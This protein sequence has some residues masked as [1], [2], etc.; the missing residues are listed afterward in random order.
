MSHLWKHWSH[1]QLYPKYELD[2]IIQSKTTDLIFCAFLGS[3]LCYKVWGALEKGAMKWELQTRHPPESEESK[4]GWYPSSLTS[5]CYWPLSLLPNSIFLP[6]RTIFLYI[7]IPCTFLT[8]CFYNALPS[9]WSAFPYTFSFS[10]WK[11][12]PSPK[13]LLKSDLIHVTIFSTQSQDN[14]TLFWTTI[15]FDQ[16]ILIACSI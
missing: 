13:V 7:D 12:F 9:S 15:Q 8:S 3:I 10:L 5:F 11:F 1:G 6:N 14:D 2:W 4:L 16:T